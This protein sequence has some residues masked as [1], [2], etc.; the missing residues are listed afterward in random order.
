MISIVLPVH[1]QADHVERVVSDC[2]SALPRVNH[3][4]ELILVPNGCRDASE[5]LC[6]ALA[7]RFPA[8]R[9]RP[10][11][12]AGWGHAVRHGLSEAGGDLLCY[13]NSARVN[14]P[15]LVLVLL[16][17]LAYPEVVVKANRKIRESAFRRL[18]SLAF[19]LECRA[20]F[21]LATWDINGTP[22]VFPRSFSRLLDLT[23]DDDLIDTEFAIVCRRAGYPVIEV[24]VISTRRYGGRSTTSLR[25]A[26]RLFTGAFR[27]WRAA[28]P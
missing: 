1:D 28:R 17:A 14:P 11:A 24:P 15:E 21:D 27:M 22:K 26:G 16:Y 18:G 19:N 7:G 4:Y 3:P 20:L 9:S 5:D 25:T 23:R 12:R 6:A 13:T 8:V 10:A 2:E